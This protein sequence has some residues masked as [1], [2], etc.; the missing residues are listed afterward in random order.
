MATLLPALLTCWATITAALAGL[1][2]YRSLIA[3]KEDDQLFLD[4]AE[5]QLER[6]QRTILTQ[7]GRL[8]PFVVGLSIAST[9]LLALI[10]GVWIYRVVLGVD[11]TLLLWNRLV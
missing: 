3:M 5:W 11:S 1:L 7:L 8:T 4:P 9:A 10:A 2:I 6:E